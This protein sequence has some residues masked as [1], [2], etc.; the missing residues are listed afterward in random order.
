MPINAVF[1]SLKEATLGQPS[2]TR[3]HPEPFSEVNG[4]VTQNA[5]ISEPCTSLL[6]GLGCGVWSSI[7]HRNRF[8]TGFG[9]GTILM[10]VEMSTALLVA[11][12]DGLHPAQ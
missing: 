5:W 8:T 3:G 10:K 1:E 12:S 11:L 7:A 9:C 2:V 4:Y 6:C